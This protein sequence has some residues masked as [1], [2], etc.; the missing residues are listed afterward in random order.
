[1]RKIPKL[2]SV[3]CLFAAIPL[4]ARSFQDSKADNWHH[5]RGPDANGVSTTATPPTRWSETKNIKWKV[6]IPG[7][8]TS[9]PIVWGDDVFLLAAVNTG[10]VDPKLPRPE[11]QPKRVFGIKHPNTSYQYIVLCLDRKTGTERWRRVAA[12]KV[13]A[14]VRPD[15]IL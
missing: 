4:Q 5:W 6:R 9:T 13:I 14:T 10:K 15:I 1:M 7:R 12:V 2:L 11:D 8:G 3:A